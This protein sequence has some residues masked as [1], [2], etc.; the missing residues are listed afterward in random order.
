[1]TLQT[2]TNFDSTTTKT[3]INFHQADEIWTVAQG[4]NVTVTADFGASAN[5][6]YDRLVNRG[7]IL[8]PS[9][10]AVFLG[11]AHDSVLNAVGASI[12][13]YGIGVMAGDYQDVVTN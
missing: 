6:Q 13:G 11:A 5:Y 12:T 9:D 3:V 1:M 10:E 4:V 7:H 2:I 8:A